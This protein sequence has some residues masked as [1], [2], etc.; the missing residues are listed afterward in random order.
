MLLVKGE[1]GMGWWLL[2]WDVGA[3]GEGIGWWRLKFV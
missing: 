2:G 1:A 3:I